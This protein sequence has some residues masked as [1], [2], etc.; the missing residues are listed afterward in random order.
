LRET[1]LH[2]QQTFLTPFE[3]EQVRMLS[4]KLDDV[5]DSIEEAGFRL[6]TCRLDPIPPEIVQIGTIVREA[7]HCLQNGVESVIHGASAVKECTAVGTLES[8]T[9]AISR[10]L[11]SDLFR[12]PR[13][14]VQLFQRKEIIEALEGIT[15]RCED[16]ADTLEEISRQWCRG[17]RERGRR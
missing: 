17:R 5:I 6:A 16:V 10:Q 4:Q 9:D 13:E 1:I 7:C 3:P 15:D 11:L 12:T 2:L 8:R 14:A